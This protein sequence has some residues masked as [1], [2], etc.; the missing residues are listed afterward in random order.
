MTQP[1]GSWQATKRCAQLSKR[2]QMLM[3]KPSFSPSH[4]LLDFSETWNEAW[5][6]VCV[7]RWWDTLQAAASSWPGA[8]LQ[9]IPT[10]AVHHA[11]TC[12][13]SAAFNY[14][15]REINS[16]LSIGNFSLKYNPIF[17]LSFIPSYLLFFA[18]FLLPHNVDLPKC[19]CRKVSGLTFCL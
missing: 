13:S 1:A 6:N 15:S 11:S 7:N 12:Y 14:F 2:H 4:V 19:G 10:E 9:S 8:A 3:G 16:D 5:G 18:R 17:P